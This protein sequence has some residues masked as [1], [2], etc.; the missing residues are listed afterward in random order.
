MGEQV[1]GQEIRRLR[2]E[3]KM[4]QEQLA[5]GICSTATLSKIE[6]GGQVP[7]RQTFRLL[8]ERLG[9]PGY[10]YAHFYTI[11]EYHF[12]LLTCEMMD[13]IAADA[14]EQVD[15]KLWQMQQFLGDENVIMQQIYRMA[16]QIWYHMCG[17]NHQDYEKQ[18]MD[19]FHMRRPACSLA[20][21]I[22]HMVLDFVEIWVVNNVAVGLLWKEDFV[23]ALQLLLHLY[24]QVRRIPKGTRNVC[25]MRGVLCNNICIGLM[26]LGRFQE[27]V[28]YCNLGIRAARQEGGLELAMQL[29]RLNMELMKYRGEMDDYYAQLVLLRQ[30]SHFLPREK[31]TE[32]VEEL[33]WARK[34]ILFL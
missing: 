21:E 6:N 29:F 4:T 32:P 3:K 16:R 20:D 27:A 11:R 26:Q 19:I 14:V 23:G 12:Y 30:I 18:C 25:K 7:S 10:S 9:E 1:F 33:L 13:A 22:P 17:M 2:V 31:Q 24:R 8:M 34:E 15:E 28:I 5:D